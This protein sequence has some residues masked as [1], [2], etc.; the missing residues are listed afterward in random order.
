MVLI[1][2]LWHDHRVF[3]LTLRWAFMSAAIFWSI[4]YRLGAQASK[5]PQFIYVNF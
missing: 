4:A 2:K 5:L 1:R 3:F